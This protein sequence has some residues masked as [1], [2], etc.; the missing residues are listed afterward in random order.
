MQIAISDKDPQDFIILERYRR[1]EDLTDVHMKSKA[2]QD[3]KTW[4]SSVSDEIVETK[5]GQSYI[6]TNVGFFR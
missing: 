4:L 3:F 1:K 5:S 6:E 2:F